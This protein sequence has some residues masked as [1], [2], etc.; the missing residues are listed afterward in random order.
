[1]RPTRRQLVT[2]GMSLAAGL[3]FSSCQEAASSAPARVL[4]LAH[5][6]D[7]HIRPG[8]IPEE[9]L[10]RALEDAESQ[11]P[12][13]LV[14]G[15]DCIMDALKAPP[16]RVKREWATFH[17]LVKDH[18]S[19][20]ML[21]CVGNHDIYGWGGESREIAHKDSTLEQLGL[22]A[23]YYFEDLKGW[24][25]IVLDSIGFAPKNRFGYLAGLGPKQF[26]WLEATIS[27]AP[28]HVCVISHIPILAAC[29]FYDGFNEQTGN[30][31]VPGQW[32][33]LDSRRI[34]TLFHRYPQVKLC[35]SGHIHLQ[36]SVQYLGVD[37]YCN[38]AVSGNYWK[39]KH[40]EF[41]PAYALVDLFEDGSSQRQMVTL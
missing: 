32:M 22:K 5:L 6:T 37:Y 12:D 8:R 11:K 4:R 34:K 17:R 18:S 7:V 21:H 41:G 35:L 31:E 38:G 1:M 27:S 24:R 25:L 30:W 15:G 28:G 19:T 13:L 9:G 2:A 14:N 40:H 29:P 26:E 3:A 36:D 20:R 39:G 33:H 10:A 16:E 23:S